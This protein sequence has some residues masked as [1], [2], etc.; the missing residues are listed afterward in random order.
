VNV[1]TG[2]QLQ[3]HLSRQTLREDVHELECRRHMQDVDITGGHVFLHK[4]DIDL[5]MLLVLVLNGVDGEVDDADFVA[6]DG[7]AIH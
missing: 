3:K 6:V 5:D 4:V 1:E 7:G 2:P